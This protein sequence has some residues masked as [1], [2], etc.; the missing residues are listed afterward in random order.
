MPDPAD[1]NRDT[2]TDSQVFDFASLPTREK[3]KLIPPI[4]FMVVVPFKTTG[5]GQRMALYKVSAR[6]AGKLRFSA[7][8]QG[9]APAPRPE[10]PPPGAGK[11][12]DLEVHSGV[13]GG[14]ATFTKPSKRDSEE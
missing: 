9:F 1:T 13:M 2:V 14:G 7:E 12:I 8:L 6:N 10:P 5:Q 3:E 11:S 4:G